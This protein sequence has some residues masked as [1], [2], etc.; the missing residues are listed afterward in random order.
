LLK[1][2]APQLAEEKPGIVS[3]KIDLFVQLHT[4]AMRNIVKRDASNHSLVSVRPFLHK[5][6]HFSFADHLRWI[7]HRKSPNLQFH[8]V[9]RVAEHFQHLIVRPIRISAQMGL[10]EETFMDG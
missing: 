1:G 10:L 8:I 9:R 6:R 2:I 7:L 5:F 4:E 3:S